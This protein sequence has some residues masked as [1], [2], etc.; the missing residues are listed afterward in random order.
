MLLLLDQVLGSPLNN[1]G[2]V[3]ALMTISRKLKNI[4]YVHLME[5]RGRYFPGNKS[6]L[7]GS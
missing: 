4:F 3:S 2:H 5:G 7:E 1:S 6:V